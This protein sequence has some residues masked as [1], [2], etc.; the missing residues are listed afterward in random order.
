MDGQIVDASIIAAPR[1]RM[2]DEERAIVKDGGI[3]EGWAGEAGAERPRC[4]LDV[5]TRPPQERP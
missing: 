5:E 2:T 1:Q 4:P 3:L